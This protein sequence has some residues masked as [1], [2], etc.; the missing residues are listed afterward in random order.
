MNTIN[1]RGEEWN[2]S[3]W[4]RNSISRLMEPITCYLLDENVLCNDYLEQLLLMSKGIKVIGRKCCPEKGIREIK[5]L[6]PNLVFLEVVM[7]EISGFDVVKVLRES[8]C[9]A[10]FI[11]V[12]AH[13]HYAVKAIRIHVFDYLLKPVDV[14]ELR[15]A[16]WRYQNG[17]SPFH[18]KESWH[19]SVR[20]KEVLQLVIRGKT[21]K[22][23][24]E[25]L[26]L[27]KYTVDMHRRHI[28]EKCGCTSTSE[29]INALIINQKGSRH[30]GGTK[31]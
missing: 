2:D 23:I 20:Q 13:S 22:Q 8:G 31:C 4:W 21:S 6:K 3:V 19:L 25:I 1:V 11:F 16:L 18:V 26:F 10:S 7:P 15:N 9:S 24:A 14:D 29:L 12:S 30:L 28:L 17:Q 27:S 5:S